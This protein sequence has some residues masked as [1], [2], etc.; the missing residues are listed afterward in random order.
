[1][2]N[3]GH[4]FKDNLIF[5]FVDGQ[6]YHYSNTPF[7]EGDCFVYKS[8]ITGDTCFGI[9][10]HASYIQKTIIRFCTCGECTMES[11]TLLMAD[12]KKVKPTFPQL[13]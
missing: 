4:F 11:R 12:C 6:Q 3:F 8:P 2:K 7:K 9:V 10:E 5:V 1:M 13:N